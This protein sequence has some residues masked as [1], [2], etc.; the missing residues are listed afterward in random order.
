M[1]V[2]DTPTVGLTWKVGDTISF[3]G[4]ATDEEDGTI[5]ASGLLWDV[6]M[7][8]CPA[9]CHEHLVQSFDGVASGS[10][11]APDHEYPS[12][13]QL[14]LTATDSHGVRT[15]VT[16]DLQPQ[17]VQLTFT[18]TPAL[19]PGLNLGF[20][21]ESARHAVHPHGDPGLDQHPRRAQPVA[22][23]HPV[24]L[25]V[26]VGRRRA[27]ATT[28]WPTPTPPTPRTSTARSTP[29]PARTSAPWPRP[30]SW[31]ETG[32]VHTV[33]GGGADIWTTSDEFRFTYQQLTGDGTI[34]ARVT[35]R[36]PTPQQRQRQGR[37]S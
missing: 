23:Q 2:I 1:P 22:R 26:V 7:Q 33:A 12:Y 19:T 6:I 36:S 15:T 34:T 14:R 4:H 29:G 25:P 21:L 20:N 9:A 11:P 13:L 24:H 30:G 16:R 17:T 28:S 8:H 37:A 18:T 3:S 32:G 5:P 10:F 27:P 31:S 35:G